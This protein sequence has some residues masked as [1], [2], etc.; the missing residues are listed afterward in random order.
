L[1]KLRVRQNRELVA[2]GAGDRFS[3]E[4]AEA[5]VIE[6]VGQLATAQA[7]RATQSSNSSSRSFLS[8]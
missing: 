5:N 8:H 6:L 4:Q 1:A 7:K 2:S 3:L